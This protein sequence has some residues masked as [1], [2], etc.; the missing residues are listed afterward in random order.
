MNIKK[1]PQNMILRNEQISREKQN[2]KKWLEFNIQHLKLDEQ[3]VFFKTAVEN[4]KEINYKWHEYTWDII[5]LK[6]TDRKNGRK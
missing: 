5:I 6:D 2:F 3:G 4:I 1:T